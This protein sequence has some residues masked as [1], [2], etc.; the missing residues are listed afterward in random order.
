MKHAD[1]YCHICKTSE[2]TLFDEFHDAVIV[3]L[4][5]S[6]GHGV[7][8]A[9]LYHKVLDVDHCDVRSKLLDRLLEDFFALLIV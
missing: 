4:A 8:L 5:G 2:Y 3:H 1:T 9:V 6:S 7:H